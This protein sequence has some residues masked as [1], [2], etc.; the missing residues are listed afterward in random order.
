MTKTRGNC[1]YSV[2][3]YFLPHFVNAFGLAVLSYRPSSLN[4]QYI[5]FKLDQMY[6][7]TFLCK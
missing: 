2:N 7:N 4:V 6:A 1:F 5:G 3:S